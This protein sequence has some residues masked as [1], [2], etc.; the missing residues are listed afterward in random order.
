[1]KA[2]ETSP[3][4][5]QHQPA[6]APTRQSSDQAAHVV[7]TARHAGLQAAIDES[8]RLL[9]QRRVL[10]AV[11]GS[12]FRRQADGLS[13][14]TTGVTV[15]QAKGSGGPK[16]AFKLE[17]V[18]DNGNIEAGIRLVKE[19]WAEA[20]EARHI[21][22]TD[23]MEANI[24]GPKYMG[25][26][27]SGYATTPY[28]SALESI[29][30]EKTLFLARLKPGLTY[31]PSTGVISYRGADMDSPVAVATLLVGAEAYAAGVRQPDL[32]RETFH[33]KGF[34]ADKTRSGDAKEY[35]ND[36]RGVKTR[37]Y[38]YVEK[39]FYQMMDFFKTETLTGRF[40]QYLR[41]GGERVRPAKSTQQAE[42]KVV[43]N[44]D[45]G[46]LNDVQLAVAHQY[47]GS[48]PDQRGVSLTSTEK[49]GGTVG[50]AGKNFRE[51]DGFRLK[52]DLAKV[53]QEV[54]LFNHYSDQGLISENMDD[55]HVKGVSTQITGVSKGT[56]KYGESVRKNRELYLEKIEPEWV[57]EIEHH[58][59]G[60]YGTELGERV[61]VTDIDSFRAQANQYARY[62][63]AFDKTLKGTELVNP[64]KV[65]EKGR[66]SALLIQEGYTAGSGKGPFVTALQAHEEVTADSLKDQYSQWHL[67]YI[68]ARVGKPN[69]KSSA[70]YA[71][72]LKK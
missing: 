38:A 44:K 64:D 62:W 33:K 29:E 2:R 61:A 10:Q 65:E 8:P 23:W 12:A 41:A 27:L 51:E 67:G 26:N 72:E 52:I 54:L 59:Q 60:G 4:T 17:D 63:E 3:D 9:E 69:F 13:G 11:F 32:P 50:N 68:R 24:K 16:L 5:A 53:P 57:V 15:V 20:K 6:A 70:D 39:N 37:R 35:V 19:S 21:V 58:P 22:K 56:Y 14:M 30:D 46:D 45:G 36:K 7:G 18:N 55:H 28:S 48:T 47:L 34:E 31:E 49:V 66:S 42:N 25:P 71:A 1:M 40:Q 43:S